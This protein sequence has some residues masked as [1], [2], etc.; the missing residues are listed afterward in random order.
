MRRSS[1]SL[2]LRRKSASKEAPN[3]DGGVGE[4]NLWRPLKWGHSPLPTQPGTVLVQ[5]DWWKLLSSPQVI[6]HCPE[7]G[8]SVVPPRRVSTESTCWH[9]VFCSWT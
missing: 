5:D 3:E 1:A 6:D 7:C 2:S 9:Q 8:R 4:G